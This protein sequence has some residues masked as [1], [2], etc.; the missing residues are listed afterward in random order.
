MQLQEKQS[1][2]RKDPTDGSDDLTVGYWA[3][4][5]S[6]YQYGPKN[7]TMG[8]CFGGYQTAEDCL[9]YCLPVVSKICSGSTVPCTKW[10]SIGGGT[11]T[12]DESV[13]MGTVS[14]AASISQAG[15]DGIIFDAESIV[16]NT[17]IVAAFQQTTAALKAA[18]FSVGVTT[19][20]SGPNACSNCI[21]GDLVSAWV[22]DPNI[23]ILS[24]Q[25]YTSGD[26]L[27]LEPTANCQSDDP[28]CTWNLWEK[29]IAPFVPSI[30]YADN[31]SVAQDYFLANYSITFGGYI[32]WKESYNGVTTYW[33][34][35]TWTDAAENCYKECPSQ[36]PSDCDEGQSCY[37]S[38]TTCSSTTSNDPGPDTP[39]TPTK[40]PPRSRHPL[41]PAERRSGVKRS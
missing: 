20:H 28:P 27:E 21:A 16:Q 36:Q 14:L 31:F 19:S 15:F 25:L 41:A 6:I 10:L 3:Y 40:K 26:T 5:W 12:M 9:T 22:A 38:I 4:S 33:C 32:Q 24:P 2:Q 39:E 17:D 1:R 29:S 23:D 11:V 7:Q 30:P 35:S 34:G 18:N 8:I 13:L 37:Q